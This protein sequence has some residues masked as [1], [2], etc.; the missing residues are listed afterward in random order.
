MSSHARLALVALVVVL[1]AAALTVGLTA[2]CSKP[3]VTG[4][5]ASAPD[6]AAVYTCPMH[7]EVTSSKP[8]QCPKCGMALVKKGGQR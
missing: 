4:A 8:G 1:L 7:P 2:G 6:A 5:A 3:A